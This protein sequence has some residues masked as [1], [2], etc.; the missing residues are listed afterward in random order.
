MIRKGLDTANVNTSSP[1][2]SIAMATYNGENY[3]REQLDSLG[4]QS[5]QPLELV[6]TD[7]GSTDRTLE[8]V[9]EFAR[10]VSFP[11]RTFRNETRL[12]YADNFLKAASL[13]QGDLI[14]FCDQ[15]DIWKS[16]KLK[17]CA[18]FFK[19][20]D[21]VLA[22]HSARVFDGNG[23]TDTYYPR[24]SRTQIL[25][26][27]S[28]SP[29]V[30]PGTDIEL[31]PGFTMVVRREVLQLANNADRPS[32][33]YG[34]D[35]WVWFLAASMGRV[36]TIADVLVQYRQHQSNVCGA[37]Q[38]FTPVHK[39]KT[40]IAVPD[41]DTMAE[42]EL[43]CSRIVS[44]LAERAPRLWR[45]AILKSSRKLAKR[46]KLHRVRMRIYRK[47][48]TFPRRALVFTRLLFSGGYW[49]DRTRTRLGVRAG[50]KDMLLGVTGLRKAVT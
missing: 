39:L 5:L 4:R 15:D 33:L 22:M 10:T 18:T 7:D 13:C 11:V 14:S 8:I 38:Q 50:V 17:T 23:D 45:P 31:R 41:Y 44:E 49:P 34:H 37:P 1:S 43:T 29:F 35:F 3:I 48:S 9:E 36:A 21:L 47:E 42:Y 6:I 26:P 12:R 2:I 25:E 24:F 27:G 16:E 30:A 28:C 40:S 20:P 46:A 19:D 32:Q